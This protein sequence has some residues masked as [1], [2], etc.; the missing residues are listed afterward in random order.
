V[1]VSTAQSRRFLFRPSESSGNL[2]NSVGHP[3]DRGYDL[4]PRPR[5]EGTRQTVAPTSVVVGVGPVP[6]DVVQ[7]GRSCGYQHERRSERP[8]GDLGITRR[9]PPA[10]RV[11]SDQHLVSATNQQGAHKG[12]TGTRKDTWVRMCLSP[13]FS[14]RKTT[15][16]WTSS[17]S[18]R[19]SFPEGVP[20]A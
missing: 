14:P 13:I 10:A 20:A 8:R 15:L 11:V 16:E 19:M 5:D 9:R 17:S 1:S 2:P 18:V 4:R 6:E 12:A 7:R 3:P